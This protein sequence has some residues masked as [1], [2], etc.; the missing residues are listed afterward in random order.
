MQKCA[1]IIEK[2]GSGM[3]QGGTWARFIFLKI[4]FAGQQPGRSDQRLRSSRRTEFENFGPE[5][6]VG[7][8]QADH[9]EGAQRPREVDRHLGCRNSGHDRKNQ[10]R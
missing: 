2:I 6:E 7:G 8:R 5:V 10:L 4:F 3:F 9:H 1:E